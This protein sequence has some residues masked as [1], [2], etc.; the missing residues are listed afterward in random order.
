MTVYA[1]LDISNPDAK[2]RYEPNWFFQS[3]YYA[4]EYAKNILAEDII[5]FNIDNVLVD[6]IGESTY[7]KYCY[8]SGK[9]VNY[10][11]IEPIYVH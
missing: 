11:V 2:V 6:Y 5:D 9:I 10:F 7:I 1:I 4:T 8:S 3:E